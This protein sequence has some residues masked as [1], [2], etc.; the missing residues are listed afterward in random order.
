VLGKR[1]A[2]D[3]TQGEA[4]GLPLPN[5]NGVVAAFFAL[6]SIGRVPAML[7][8]TVGVA[9]MRSACMTA[10]IR[11][12]VTARAFVD[13][14]RLHDVI[15]ALE[16]DGLRIVWLED[17]GATIGAFE[18][19]RAAGRGPCRTPPPKARHRRRCARRD[20]LLHQRFRG[21]PRALS[22]PTATCCRTAHNSPHGSISTR[23][24]SCSTPCR[25]STPS[26]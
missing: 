17:V 21:V 3:T 25:Y 11:T 14:A 4:V 9:N 10:A 12:V 16:A 18:K 22:S 1:L 7:N 19:L 5:V 26:A 23:P 24:T 20:P 15:A 8:F 6:Q 2:Q 13:Q